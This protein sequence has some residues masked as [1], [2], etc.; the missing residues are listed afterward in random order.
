MWCGLIKPVYSPGAMVASFSFM[1]GHLRTWVVVFVQVRWSYTWV[2]VCVW[3]Q[4]DVV[5]GM[6]MDAL[7]LLRVVVVVVV[8]G[9]GCR[10]IVVD[11]LWTLD[12]VV[13]VV[14]GCVVVLI[15]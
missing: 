7:Q 9:C 4:V 6:N 5:M 11:A 2:V 12:V 3:G 10:V 8:M 1:S 15:R 13:V 14:R